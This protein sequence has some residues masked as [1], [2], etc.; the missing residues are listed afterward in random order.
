MVKMGSG[1]VFP[2]KEVGCQGAEDVFCGIM[3]INYYILW[4]LATICG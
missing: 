1:L 4:L 2:L 3:T